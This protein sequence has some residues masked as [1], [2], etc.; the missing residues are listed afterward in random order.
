MQTVAVTRTLDA[1]PD[2]VRDA[3]QDVGPFMRSAGFDDVTVDGDLVRLTNRVGM[4]TIELELRLEA[5]DGAVLAYVQED[6]LFDEMETWYEVDPAGD[7]TRVEATTEFQVDVDLVGF[8]L[9]ATVIKR[10]R[11]QE[12]EMQMEYLDDL[13]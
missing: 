13:D 4:A 7:G 5:R 12:L 8:L 2:R 9:D 6:G 10:Q 3:I 1:P 11:T